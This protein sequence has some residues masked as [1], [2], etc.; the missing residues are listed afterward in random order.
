M[1][2][3]T[4]VIDALG[5]ITTY[6]YD[7]EGNQLSITN[8]LGRTVNFE[9]DAL[10]R[11]KLEIQPNGSSREFTFDGNGN[12]ISRRNYDNNVT[13][14]EYDKLNRLTNRS[15]P[16]GTNCSYTYDVAGKMTSANNAN[17]NISFTYDNANRLTSET[18]NSKATATAYDVAA[19]KKTI[20]Y[21]GG[22]LIEYDLD[23]RER[24]T[25]IKNNGSNAATYTYDL[26]NR[27]LSKTYGNGVIT[28]Y[29][30]NKNDQITG[31]T[32][33]PNQ[34]INFVMAYDGEGNRLYEEKSHKSTNSEQY[35]Y[36][37]LNRLTE[38][39]IG[40]LNGGFIS[41]SLD[42][43]M[44]NYDALNNRLSFEKNG[45][46]TSYSSNS[47]N[48]YTSFVTSNGTSSISHS[49]NGNLLSDGDH[50]YAY[51][52]D[53]R[54][55]SIDGGATATY[56]YDALGRRI[57]KISGGITTNYYY[58][59]DH[60]IE[61]R[62]GSDDI[63]ANFVYS[64]LEDDQVVMI[65]DS[66][67]YY[68]HHN[69]IGS[70]VGVTDDVG[71]IM[72][73]YEYDGYGTPKFFD[74]AYTPIPSSAIENNY[75][76]TGREFDPESFLYNLKSRHYH[77]QLGRFVQRDPLGFD[78]GLNL[79]QYVESN[80]TSWIDPEGLSSEY[81]CKR[82]VT[83]KEFS[84]KKIKDVTKRFGLREIAVLVDFQTKNCGKCCEASKNIGISNEISF[85]V[86]VQTKFGSPSVDIKVAEFRIGWYGRIT[87]A[88]SVKGGIDQCNR[89]FG[90]GCLG[91]G[92][93]IGLEAYATSS[94]ID[95]GGR[96]GLSVS[97]NVC[98]ECNNGGC[99]V[100]FK[101]CYELRSRFWAKVN[102]PFIG[103]IN[104]FV[105]YGDGAC[106]E[107]MQLY[108]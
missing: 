50:I 38:S 77:P 70:V 14:Y 53:N 58:N 10:N 105:E 16:D 86:S 36:D 80:P 46:S 19:K 66:N 72:E 51:D 9:Y 78:E 25:S 55:I 94:I 6:Q 8:A 43:S 61:E 93:E 37:A 79:Y 91:L 73:R 87:V 21:P 99:S 57:R 7:A 83:R 100:F 34:V 64:Q 23:F 49:S 101:P 56:F 32:V 69:A 39:R 17:A 63:I 60:I 44:F 52:Y 97:G 30:Y 104:R 28:S 84:L 24:A 15:Y 82:T 4:S 59:E 62:N 33:N 3:N 65:R 40:M 31:I 20:T 35:L 89:S 67:I 13:T 98:L 12:V 90:G 74:G 88:G 76:F 102:V 54:I 95:A 107:K 45:V 18:M 96:G 71:D 108:P 68:Y 92:G 29:S 42:S 27:L 81:G 5:Q 1:N 103:K 26:G 41:A 85:S 75:L 11:Q 2:R 48:Q 22:R 106:F 47:L